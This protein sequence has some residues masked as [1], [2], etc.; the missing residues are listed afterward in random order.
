MELQ[1]F[2]LQDDCKHLKKMQFLQFA[3]I[4]QKDA[5]I[6]IFVNPHP[7]RLHPTVSTIKNLE[8]QS[9]IIN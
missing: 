4:V 7:S 6:Q 3:T 1:D 2:I 5:K 9:F 8:T